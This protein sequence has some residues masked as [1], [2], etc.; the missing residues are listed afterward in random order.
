MDYVDCIIYLIENGELVQKAAYGPKNPQDFDI[1]NP[2]KLQIGEGICGTVAKTGEA[3][4]IGDTSKD[5][6][7]KVDDEIRYS[8]IT[9]PMKFKGEVIGLIDSEHP[10]KN[11]FKKE[12]LEILETIASMMAVKIIQAKATEELK[13][14]EENLKIKVEEKTS[15]L[16]HSLEKLQAYNLEINE[17]NRQKEVL[18][19]EIHHR[20]KNNLQIISSLMSLHM[21]KTSNIEAHDVFNDCKNRVNSMSLIH[22]QL[23]TNEDLGR[24]QASSYIIELGQELLISTNVANEI[25]IEYDVQDVF[26]SLDI[27][28]PLGLIINE[29]LINCFKYAFPENKGLIQIYLHENQNSIKMIVSDDG[30]GFD[31]SKKSDDSLGLEL[32]EALSDQLNGT[33]QLSS[34]SKGTKAELEFTVQGQAPYFY[35]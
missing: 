14:N 28:V 4:I 29:L 8:E 20:V 19:K 24:I 34:S 23:Y 1:K 30:I 6:R 7:Y 10:E 2:I 3:E 15:E 12:D 18:L 16:T 31:E 9:V 17:S 22:E 11:F 33:F 32:I 35:K 27:S 26:F 5:P 13:K 25:S 21:H